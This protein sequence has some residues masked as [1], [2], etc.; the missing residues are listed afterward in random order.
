MPLRILVIDDEP[1]MGT[2]LKVTMRAHADV[3]SELSAEAAWRRLEAGE[4]FDVILCDL[5]LPEVT[6]MELHGRLMER[7]P[8]LAERMIFMTGGA[9]TQEATEFLHRARNLHV[10]KPFELDELLDAI[11]VLRDRLE[12]EQ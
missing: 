4:E 8:A 2:T 7:S 1:M 3:T 5:M 9:Y 6:G 10:D 11:A 12:A